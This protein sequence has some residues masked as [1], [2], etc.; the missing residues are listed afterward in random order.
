MWNF[1][2]RSAEVQQLAEL[3]TS[4][5]PVSPGEAA[6]HSDGVCGIRKTP[7]GPFLLRL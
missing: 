7:A 3:G 6:G 1:G 4:W 2:C 5:V